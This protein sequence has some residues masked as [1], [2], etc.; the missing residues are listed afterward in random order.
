M[1]HFNVGQGLGYTFL[2]SPGLGTR[3][4]DN[5]DQILDVERGHEVLSKDLGTLSYTFASEE[6]LHFDIPRSVHG[7]S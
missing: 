7:Y 6:S 1:I 3:W 4:E 2:E 5:L